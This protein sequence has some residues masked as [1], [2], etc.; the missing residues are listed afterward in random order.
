M[1]SRTGSDN[2][3]QIRTTIWNIVF[4]S[5]RRPSRSNAQRR[6]GARA[7][8]GQEYFLIESAHARHTKGHRNPREMSL[9]RLSDSR[10]QFVHGPIVHFE[11]NSVVMRASSLAELRDEF[12]H[13]AT[14]F[15]VPVREGEFIFGV[16]PLG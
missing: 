2:F 1:A 14:D 7:A 9:L 16:H 8:S 15:V 11:R 6:P 5:G 3:E 10:Q 13:R 4:S 12:W